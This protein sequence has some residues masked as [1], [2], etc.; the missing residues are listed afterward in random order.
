MEFDQSH[1]CFMILSSLD[2]LVI[3]WDNLSSWDNLVISLENMPEKDLTVQYLS[4]RLVE[5]DQR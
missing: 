2:N 4:G 1:H 5:E 3:N